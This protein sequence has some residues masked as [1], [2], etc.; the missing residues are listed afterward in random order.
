M[1]LD[2]RELASLIWLAVFTAW[3]VSVRSVRGSIK[4]LLGAFLVPAISITL[5]LMAGYVALTVLA[6]QRV[7][8]WNISQLKDTMIWVLGFAFLTLFETPQISRSVGRLKS[9]ILDVIS[10]V[11]VIEFFMNLYVMSLW[12]ELL[13]VP[14]VTCGGLLLVVAERSKEHASAGAFLRTVQALIGFGL[15]FFVVFRIVGDFKQLAT[16]QTLR[17]LLLPAVLSVLYVPFVYVMALYMAYD[18]LFRRFGFLI[19][20]LSVRTHAR[21][22]TLAVC[23]LNLSAVIDWSKTVAPLRF[24]SK[25]AVDVGL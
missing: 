18:S 10:I 15:L 8:F 5:V 16:L 21:V 6:L 17:N 20:D 7:G 14:A 22:R 12:L 2:N 23:H 4:P 11:L 3:A 24:E 25:E 1:E 19:G 13:L 9:A